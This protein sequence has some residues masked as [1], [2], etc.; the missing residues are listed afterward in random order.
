MAV[1]S[2]GERRMVCIARALMTRPRL[3]LMDEACAGLDFIT[4]EAF[5]KNLKHVAGLPFKPC[6]IF[7]THHV[8]EVRPLFSHIL[9]LSKGRVCALGPVKETLNSNSLSRMFGASL[10]LSRCSQGYTLDYA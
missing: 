6:I 3:L 4:R 9:L 1:L 7:A 2:Q 8:E 5:L 10:V